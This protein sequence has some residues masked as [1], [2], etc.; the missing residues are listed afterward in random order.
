MSLSLIFTLTESISSKGVDLWRQ[1]WKVQGSEV[2]SPVMRF[3]AHEL[4]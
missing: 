4:S 3:F 1:R 2:K